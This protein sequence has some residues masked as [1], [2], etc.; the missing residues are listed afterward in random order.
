MPIYLILC[1]ARVNKIVQNINHHIILTFISS[2]FYILLLLSEPSQQHNTTSL[3]WVGHENDFA[4]PTPPITQNKFNG[5]LQ[6]PQNILTT[7]L[8]SVISN[9]NT[10][11]NNNNTNNSNKNNNKIKTNKNTNTNDK[12]TTTI[13]TTTTQ[14]QRKPQEPQLNIY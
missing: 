12:T 7:T 4:N 1:E 8:F 5:S 6:E 14:P 2:S 13:S 10:T 3:S 9:N 11:N